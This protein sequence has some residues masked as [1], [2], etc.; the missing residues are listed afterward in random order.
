[1]LDYIV[2]LMEVQIIC[3]GSMSLQATKG[4][5]DDANRPACLTCWQNFGLLDGEDA[6]LVIGLMDVLYE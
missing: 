5:H 2:P 6:Q 3:M 4:W 1:M